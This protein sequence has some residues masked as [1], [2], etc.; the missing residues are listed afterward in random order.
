MVLPSLSTQRKAYRINLLKQ[1]ALRQAQEVRYP[2][3]IE[4]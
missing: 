3:S 1:E 4:T 2:N